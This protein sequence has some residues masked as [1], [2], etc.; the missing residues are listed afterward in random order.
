[1]RATSMERFNNK[2]M[3][4][5]EKYKGSFD[6]FLT[7]KSYT[8]YVIVPTYCYQLVFPKAKRIRFMWLAQKILQLLALS[9]ATLFIFLEYTFPLL[10]QSKNYFKRPINFLDI[11]PYVD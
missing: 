9:L 3:R 1:M 5:I 4:I 11:Y 2:N 6:K 10:T 8:Y 7:V